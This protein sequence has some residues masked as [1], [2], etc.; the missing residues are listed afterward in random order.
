MKRRNSERFEEAARRHPAAQLALWVALIFVQM[1]V[2]NRLEVR[3]EA[4][5]T[6][7]VEHEIVYHEVEGAAEIPSQV[8]V[9]VRDGDAQAE[10]VCDLT[11]VA[12]EGLAWKEGFVLPVTFHVYDAGAYLLDG[13]VIPG[14]DEK[15]QLQGYEEILLREAG[16]STDQYRVREVRW[17]GESY[18]DEA[19]ELCRD[20]V[21][22]GEMLVRDVRAR[23]AGTAVFPVREPAPTVVTRERAAVTEETEAAE[24]ETA[25]PETI[26]QEQEIRVEAASPAVSISGVEA[27]PETPGDGRSGLARLWQRITRTLLVAVGIG[28][29]LFFLGLL[30]LAGLRMAKM[31]GLWYSNRRKNHKGD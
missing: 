30:L 10:A 16:L 18:T 3:A 4:P 22:V 24:M 14:N 19:G 17:D 25:E 31:V 9:T 11:E 5:V 27:E 12:E 13:Q 6:H 7:P 26:L 8:T 1:A 15:P 20:A 2:V 21:A 28:A 23:Y 29:L